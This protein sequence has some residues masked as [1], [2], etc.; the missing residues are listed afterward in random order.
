MHLKPKP[1]AETYRCV[2]VSAPV[3]TAL[4]VY[5]NCIQMIGMV[6][7]LKESGGLFAS[8]IKVEGERSGL[9]QS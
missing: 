9:L 8:D 4:R 5:H 6:H 7:P 3:Y 2:C 1:V